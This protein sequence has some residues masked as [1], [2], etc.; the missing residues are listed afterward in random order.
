MSDKYSDESL[1]ERLN[2]IKQTADELPVALIIHRIVDL[3]V[4]YMNLPGLNA[5]GTTLEEITAL[6]QETY[7]STFFHPDDSKDYVPKIINMMKSRSAEKL[8][9]FQRFR[10]PADKDWKLCAANTRVFSSDNEGQPSHLITT[11]A[12]LDD[13]HQIT[14]KVNRLI[15]EIDFLRKNSLLFSK[16]TNREKDVL[17]L[18]SA[19][20]NSGAVAEKLFISATTVDT[21]RRNIRNKLGLKNNY[22]ALMFAQA[23]NLM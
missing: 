12:T 14:A 6:D 18:T 5:L 4:V 10:N 2:N 1:T 17:R 13:E 3:K 23:F 8:S 16:L 22:D 19:G 21:H 20:M 11:A 9:Y 15:D 7:Y